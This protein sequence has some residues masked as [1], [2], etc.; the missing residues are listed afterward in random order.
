MRIDAQRIH[1]PGTR[2]GDLAPDS[3]QSALGERWDMGLR[4]RGRR[5]RNECRSCRR[6]RS[7]AAADTPLD[8]RPEMSRS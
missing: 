7:P 6:A 2:E 5:A 1:A 4:S 3:N 8:W